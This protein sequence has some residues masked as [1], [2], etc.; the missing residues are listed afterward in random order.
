MAVRAN[1]GPSPDSV[2]MLVHYRIRLT[3]FFSWGSTPRLGIRCAIPLV[4]IAWMLASTG[5]GGGRNRPTR[6]KNT[7]LLGSFN[8][9]I[10]DIHDSNTVMFTKY[11]KLILFCLK[12]PNRLKP[13]LRVQGTP[14]LVIIYFPQHSVFSPYSRR[15]SPV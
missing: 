2:L 10:L 7:Y 3:N 4:S 11:Y 13:G 14:F 9:Y 1:T 5:D 12:H 15:S 8:I 6:S